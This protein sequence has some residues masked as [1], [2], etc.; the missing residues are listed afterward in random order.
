[1]KDGKEAT[2]PRQII[3]E[4]LEKS[5]TSG[6]VRKTLTTI[7]SLFPAN[8]SYL[9]IMDNV[10]LDKALKDLANFLTSYISNAN[11]KLAA[12][13][14][15]LSPRNKSQVL[16]MFPNSLCVTQHRLIP[17]YTSPLLDD[18]NEALHVCMY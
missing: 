5:N 8:Q 13:L 9:R 15:F 11:T 3:N 1:M 10:Q 18:N 4:A 16:A 14:E 6:Q 12:E 17:L 2:L 7:M